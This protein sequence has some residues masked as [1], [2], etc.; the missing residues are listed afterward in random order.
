LR[1]IKGIDTNTYGQLIVDSITHMWEAAMAAFGGRLTSIGTIPVTAWGK[2]KKPYK[3][4]MNYSMASPLHFIICGR[5]GTL[6]ETDENTEE[7]KA[8]GKK[9]KAEG[10]TPYEPHILLRM[11]APRP[12]KRDEVADIVAF[13]EKDR[14]GV[15]SGR[16][17]VNPTFD[18]LIA[19]ILPLL[20]VSQAQMSSGEESALLD[21]ETLAQQDAERATFSADK[22][23]ELSAKLDLVTTVKDVKKLG[24]EITSQLK[25]QMTVADVASLREKYTNRL[26]ELSR[27]ESA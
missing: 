8:V 19:R 11:E 10:E 13:A 3:E 26:D 2:I 16:M 25:A 15:L 20:G 14:T 5:E 7:L 6:Y 23:K 1:E 4:L 21:A 27:K 24:G 9:M 17:F 22:L 18:T 12:K